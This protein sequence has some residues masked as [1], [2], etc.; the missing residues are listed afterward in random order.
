MTRPRKALVSVQDT[1]YYRVV[2]RCVR[3]RFLC[4]ILSLG[5]SIL[6]GPSVADS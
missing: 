5:Q 4:G 6:A 2:S 1:P 3:R